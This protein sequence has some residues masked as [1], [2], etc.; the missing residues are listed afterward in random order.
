M[1]AAGLVYVKQVLEA[2]PKEVAVVSGLDAETVAKI[3][4]ALQK[5]AAGASKS[6]PPRPPSKAPKKVAASEESTPPDITPD[7]RKDSPSSPRSSSKPEPPAESMRP[8]S[9][10]EEGH[11]HTPKGREASDEA[12]GR[13]VHDE[14][15]LEE[16]RGEATHLR[17]TIETLRE[18]ITTLERDCD[19]LR[20]AAIATK[21]QAVTRLTRL[22]K[23]E[24]KRATLDRDHAQTL[25]DLERVAVSLK[26]QELE[27]RATL[28]ELT[29]LSDD[30]ASLT[31]HVTHGL[32]TRSGS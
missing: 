14:L 26:E 4:R 28:D 15:A 32:Q 9:I 8:P 30:T 6:P 21:S 12:V 3:V 19:R 29:S 10:L 5:R 16:A 7:E 25:A 22:G 27:R 23:V 31:E 13:L 20:K 17:A 11:P 1:L 24:T 18:D 2:D